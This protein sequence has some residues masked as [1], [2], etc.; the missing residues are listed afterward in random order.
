MEGLLLIVI[1]VEAAVRIHKIVQRLSQVAKVGYVLAVLADET[2]KRSD[3][4]FVRRN[5]ERSDSGDFDRIDSDA[6]LADLLSWIF[7]PE[8]E[9]G[10]VIRGSLGAAWRCWQTQ[11]KAGA[12]LPR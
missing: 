5:R 6:E 10:S 12:L 4:L 11:T 9:G 1:P 8:K 3:L 7:G 2:E